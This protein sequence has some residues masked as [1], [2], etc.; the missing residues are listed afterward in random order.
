MAVVRIRPKVGLKLYYTG[1]TDK[2]SIVRIRPKVGLKYRIK[3]NL[4]QPLESQ[5]QT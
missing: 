2:L 4:I 1:Q 3:R 5:N